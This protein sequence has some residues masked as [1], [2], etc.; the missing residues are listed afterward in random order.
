MSNA[1]ATLADPLNPVTDE[2]LSNP[3]PTFDE[4][5]ST[6]PI[7]WSKKSKY[8]LVSD[9]EIGNEATK[10][11]RFEKHLENWNQVNPITKMLPGPSHLIKA[12][13]SWM[14]NENPPKHTHLRSLVNKAFSPKMIQQM[15]EKIQTCADRLIDNVVA[16]GKMEFIGEFAFLLPITVI[17]QMLGVPSQDHEKFRVWS[18]ILT[19]TV[20]PT[21]ITDMRVLNA[22]NHAHD[23]LA[24]YLKPLV[25]ERRKNPQSDLISALVTAEVDGAKL[26]EEDVIGNA[27]LMLVA[28]HETTVNLISNGLLALLQHPD[29]LKLLKEDPELIDSAIEEFLR[30]DSPVQTVRRLAGEDMEFHGE[31]LRKG[32]MLII[33]LGACNRDP[34]AFENADKCD[35]TRKENKHIAFSSGIHHCLGATL[36]RVEGKIAI[37]TLLRRLPNIRLKPEQKFVYKR[38]FNL[39][40]LKEMHVLF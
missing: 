6:A 2:F 20:E 26:S 1:K 11:L 8:W 21:A 18:N 31:H 9:Y 34:K 25:D 29:Q 7:F 39:R 37:N 4:M 33:F 23:E 27:M 19:Q 32:D 17:T 13:S 3:Y 14:I 16:A 5:R 35:I 28:G 38:P 10:D 22:S 40:G 15:Q 36:A 12:R 30:Y 24:K